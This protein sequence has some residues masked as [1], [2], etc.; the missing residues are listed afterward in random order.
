MTPS[1]HP[2]CLDT[3][4]PLLPVEQLPDTTRHDRPSLIFD[5]EVSFLPED[6]RLTCAPDLPTMTV[7]RTA[8][9]TPY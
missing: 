4:D 2:T 8:H 9:L 3:G 5:L 6:S 1:S 7:T